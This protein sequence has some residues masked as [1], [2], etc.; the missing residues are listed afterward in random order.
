MTIATLYGLLVCCSVNN[1][2]LRHFYNDT[3]NDNTSH[4]QQMTNKKTTTKC[5]LKCHTF[6]IS[7]RDCAFTVHAA[8][9]SYPALY[10]QHDSQIGRD[11]DLWICK[12]CNEHIC[13]NGSFGIEICRLWT[14]DESD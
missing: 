9:T 1:K 13:W 4:K 11:R 2:D 10:S 3:D 6:Q 14:L 7:T 8:N 5:R 12:K